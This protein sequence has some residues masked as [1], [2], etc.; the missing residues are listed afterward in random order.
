MDLKTVATKTEMRSDRKEPTKK[1]H[2]DNYT[3]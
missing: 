2:Q 3:N 1:T